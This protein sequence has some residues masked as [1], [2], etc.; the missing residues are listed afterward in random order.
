MVRPSKVLWVK[1]LQRKQLP[2][3]SFST[4]VDERG[5]PGESI[6]QRRLGNERAWLRLKNQ[7]GPVNV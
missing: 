3:R 7:L 5:F 4:S 1:L 2:Q 6:D